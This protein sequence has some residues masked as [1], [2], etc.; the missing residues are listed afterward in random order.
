MYSSGQIFSSAMTLSTSA[1]T[2]FSTFKC[3]MRPLAWDPFNT[4]SIDLTGS[5]KGFPCCLIMWHTNKGFFSKTYIVKFPTFGATKPILLYITLMCPLSIWRRSRYDNIDICLKRWEQQI[6]VFN[7][8]VVCVCYKTRQQ[9]SSS[10]YIH[11]ITLMCN[12]IINKTISICR[13]PISTC[14][15]QTANIYL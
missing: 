14:R 12:I 9:K 13:Q 11:V 6:L 7:L 8:F 5:L 15:V 3:A 10:K 1:P 2:W 4:L